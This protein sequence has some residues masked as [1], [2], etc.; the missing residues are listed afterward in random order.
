MI[1]LKAVQ[2]P[3]P[4]DVTAPRKY[5]VSTQS[6]GEVTLETL[7][8]AISEKCTLTEPDV[9]AVLSAL[10]IEM[11]SHLMDG[12]IV[13]FGSFGS[14]QLSLNSNGVDTLAEA[15]RYQVKSAKVRFRP[16][17]KIQESLKV[18]KFNFTTKA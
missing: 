9:L 5:Y 4:K 18:L 10:T 14:F 8:E 1:Q 3:N 6:A 13:R 2:R 7:S 16:G 15:S 17:Q 11:K 12:K